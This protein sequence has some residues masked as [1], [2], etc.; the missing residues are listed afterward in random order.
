MDYSFLDVLLDSAFVIRQDKSIHYCNEAAA[1]LC[2]SS[3]KRMMRGRPIFE[4]I[5]FSDDQLWVMP[6][7]VKG[8]DQVYPLTEIEYS[9]PGQVEKR[10]KVQMT[11][12][13]FTGD[14]EKMWMVLI[15]DVTVEEVL[16]EKY[17]LQLEQLESY[18][19]N[20]EKMVEE[21]TQELKTANH[22]LSAIMNSLGQGFLVF[23]KS[24]KCLDVY[25]KACEVV[26]ESKPAGE[27]IVSVLNFTNEEKE[28]FQMW[29]QAIF[30]EVLSFE[31]LK[32]LGPQNYKHSRDKFIT[33]DFFALYD[34]DNKIQ[35]IVLVATDKSGEMD[36]QLALEQERSYAKMIIKFVTNRRL[37]SYFIDSVPRTLE[38]LRTQIYKTNMD[39]N[40]IFRRVHTLEGEAAT[41][42][43]QNIFTKAKALQQVVSQ[44][45]KVGPTDNFREDFI[46]SLQ[47]LSEASKE[48]FDKNSDLI[49]LLE[50][51]NRSGRVEVPK[52]LI[53]DYYKIFQQSG[54]DQELN[55]R[56][57][58]DFAK[59]SFFEEIK[60][61]NTV[62][63]QVADKRGKRVRAIHFE[64]EDIRIDPDLFEGLLSSFVHIFRN[65]VDHGLEDPEERLTLG[66]AEEGLVKIV[67][68]KEIG[69]NREFLRIQII[70]DGRG[71]DPEKIRTKL[72]E[73]EP[74]KDWSKIDDHVIIQEI[75]NP[76]FSS[77]DE[78][79]EFSGRGVG[80]DAVKTEVLK[81]SGRIEVFSVVGKGTII[82]IMVPEV[83]N[84]S[85]LKSA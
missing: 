35:N 49:E 32:D 39:L 74:S 55:D 37:F 38:Y 64:G 19:K 54:L 78:V 2:H 76:G 17:K 24:G 67:A 22:L 75:F 13:P 63:K 81:L 51:S 20:L 85:I 26:L 69:S 36:A 70:D 57:L 68:N 40:E 27:N 84:P 33:L 58:S 1:Q 72:Q 42:S 73:K 29:M 5:K 46:L 30:S 12:S 9:L 50:Y 31:S 59:T 65:I 52:T 11:I 25:T 10:G 47:Q 14:N 62:L 15:R 56:F 79:G 48:F 77:K 4:Y 8:Y 53:F 23:D 60:Y 61:G 44:A 82:N 66:K 41:L 3:I 83:H 16:H 18:S 7:G 6:E 43:I 28:Q 21:R 80:M 34:D 45:K 71:I